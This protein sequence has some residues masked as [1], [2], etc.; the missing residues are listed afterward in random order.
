[1]I[2]EAVRRMLADAPD[3]EFH[4]CADPTQALATAERVAPTVILQDLVMPQLDGLL[5]VRFFRANPKT[6]EVPLIVLST[7]EDPAVKAEAF[8]RGANDYLVKLPDAREL[9]ARVRYHSRGY[10]AMLERAET[11]NALVESQRQLEVRNRFIRETFGRY[12]S[13]E[14]VDS[15]LDSPEALKLGG[16]RRKAT[17]MMTD[18]RGFTSLAES[19]PPEKTV[20]VIN[21]YLE[22]MT[23]VIV[24]HQGTIDEFIGDAILVIFGAPVL[25]PDDAER[26]VVCAVEMQLAMEEVNARAQAQGLPA[27]DMGIGINTGEVVVGN[28]GS[29]KR[30]KYGVVGSAVNLT[31]R[32]ETYTIGQQILIS[33][34][35]Y[36]EVSS[37]VEV[38]D[39]MEVHP[40]GVA[41]P[42]TIHSVRGV[43]GRYGL[44]LPSLHAELVTPR[45]EVAVRYGVLEGKD[46]GT[47]LCSGR[48]ARLSTRDA[49]VVGAE[50]PAPLSNLRVVVQGPDGR[51]VDGDAY[52][53]VRGPDAESGGF[54]VRFTS[55]PPGVS[56][57]LA[58]AARG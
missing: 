20:A 54:L 41:A 17:V 42:I 47:S 16:E 49:V 55:V 8:A 30:A 28:I 9:V 21:N 27:V 2:G 11:F 53:K 51:P 6:R 5:L 40:K 13:D 4:Y 43:G 23:D 25:R 12:L 26:A 29:K 38:D 44:R 46:A 14:V 22:G 33:P 32:I 52:A 45:E 48:L 24:K 3:V 10:I 50:M 37:L 1:M 56:A 39:R 35:T 36:Q 18:L 57:V 7:K 34:T 31:S 19:M 58:R 15:L